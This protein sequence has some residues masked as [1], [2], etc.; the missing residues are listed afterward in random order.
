MRVQDVP[1]P[2]V[3]AACAAVLLVLLTAALAGAPCAAAQQAPPKPHS[4]EPYPYCV[5]NPD[6]VAPA[7]APSP[8]KP[9]P[10]SEPPPLPLLDQQGYEGHGNGLFS[11][12]DGYGRDLHNYDLFANLPSLLSDPM[13]TIWLWLGN[14]G[15]AVGKYS[16]GFSVWFTEWSMTAG[17]VDWVKAPAESLEQV[18][19]TSIIG[20]LHL[21]QIALLIAVCYL[22][23][24]FV[25]GFTTRAWREMLS[26]IVIN[27]L[28]V[29]VITHP[30]GFLVGDDGVLSLS[31]ALGTDVSAIV[32]GQ[33]PGGTGNPAAPIGQALIDN[34]LVTPW[35]LLNYGSAITGDRK[36][37]GACR[38]SVKKVLDDGPWSGKDDSTKARELGGCPDRYG[39]YNEV[40]DADRAF[41]AWGYAIAM[42]LFA[43]L[44]V[45]LNAIQV[46]APYL[47]LFEGLLL[48]LALVIAVVPAW[49]HQLAYR[50]SS[51]AATVAKVLMGMLFLAVMTVIVR[52]LMTADL[53]PALVRFSVIDLVVFSGFLFR[54]RLAANVARVRS[55]VSAGMQ[56]LGQPRT[57]PKPL[58][59]PIVA[60]GPHRISR[61]VKAG[62]D[63]FAEAV[64]P[65]GEL[66]NRLVTAGKTGGKAGSKV[67]SYTIGA[68]VSWPRAAHRASTALTSKGNAAKAALGRQ[69]AAAKAYGVHYAS[70]LGTMSGARPAWH[71]VTTAAAAVQARHGAAEEKPYLADEVATQV[72]ARIAATPTFTGTNH[73]TPAEPKSP[74]D[75]TS[76]PPGML[77]PPVSW[78]QRLRDRMNQNKGA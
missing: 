28:A 29:S 31:R 18:W 17:V 72:P 66:K 57:A 41:G 40:A 6:V 11:I 34:L 7:P 64:A 61:T 73:A 9:V 48:A 55:R 38:Y 51:I 77:A 30:V 53:G 74:P 19:Q 67:L 1:R 12:D 3:T 46:L 70:G 26:T 25:R 47:L 20:D 71:A 56:R 75:A 15:F 54:K 44:T 39:K 32:L 5:T 50:V 10:P 24:L 8:G 2:N 62:T 36:A 43:I 22:G 69:A 21:R 37:D 52:S 76:L 33:Q 58:P 16:V 4:C 78:S 14:M 63:A 60:P 49:Q 23:F 35:E 65:V 59:E 27:A 68:P 42:V 13:P 45:C